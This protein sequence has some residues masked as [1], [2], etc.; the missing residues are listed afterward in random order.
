MLRQ[1]KKRKKISGFEPGASS[2][3]K[4]LHRAGKKVRGGQLSKHLKKR[5][6]ISYLCA[7]RPDGQGS[8]LKAQPSRKTCGKMGL[9]AVH[10]RRKRKYVDR[11]VPQSEAFE[12]CSALTD[13]KNGSKGQ[14]YDCVNIL[15]QKNCRF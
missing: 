14:R 4:I 3:R 13:H 10:K 2:S 8:I 1:Q 11:P 5:S 12:L 6:F 7:D 9:S 15:Q